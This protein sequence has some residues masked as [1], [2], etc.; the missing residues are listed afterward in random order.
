MNNN[1]DIECIMC[2]DETINS[3]F[4]KYQHICGTYDIHQSCL[5]NWFI[6]NSH[7]CIICR[8]NIISSSDSESNNSSRELTNSSREST[9]TSNLDTS[10]DADIESTNDYINPIISIQ[11][12]PYNSYDDS[13]SYN[14]NRNTCNKFIC[15]ILF[16]SIFFLIVIF[17]FFL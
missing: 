9:D 14:Q 15:A 13:I 6:E 10:Y 3:H 8:N 7:S 1:N 4:I 16:I 11:D 12:H 5:D 2:Q 17:L